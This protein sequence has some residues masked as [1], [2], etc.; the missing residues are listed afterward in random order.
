M[1]PLRFIISIAFGVSVAVTSAASGQSYPSKPI[2]M[3]TTDPGGSGDIALRLIGPD[4]SASLGQP[5]A[6]DKQPLSI[7]G[8]I[9]ARAGARG[10]PAA[11]DG[12]PL[13]TEAP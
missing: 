9:V 3:L 1:L 11:G 5:L 4:V 10:L 6:L 2:R 13:R 12:T 8:E 7:A